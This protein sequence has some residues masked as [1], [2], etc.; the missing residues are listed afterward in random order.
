MNI[1]RDSEVLVLDYAH[2]R[3]GITAPASIVQPNM[4]SVAAQSLYSVKSS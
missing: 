2:G 4:E 1:D 3:P